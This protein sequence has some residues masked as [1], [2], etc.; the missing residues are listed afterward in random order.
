[1]L[2]NDFRAWVSLLTPYL[3]F[4][5][6]NFRIPDCRDLSVGLLRRLIQYLFRRPIPDYFYQPSCG[7]RLP[8]LHPRRK[9]TCRDTPEIGSDSGQPLEPI[10][11]FSNAHEPNRAGSA[12]PGLSDLLVRELYCGCDAW[13]RMIIGVESCR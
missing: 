2:S 7:G 1:M 12:R 8:P 10:Q 11:T 13:Q 4:Q 5:I 6:R 3:L 9:L